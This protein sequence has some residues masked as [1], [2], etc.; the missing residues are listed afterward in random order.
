M[1][2]NPVVYFIILIREIVKENHAGLSYTNENKLC[3]DTFS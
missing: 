1:L 3:K 2:S